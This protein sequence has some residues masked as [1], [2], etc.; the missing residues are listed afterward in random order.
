MIS[1]KSPE[2]GSKDKKNF[3]SKEDGIYVCDNYDLGLD[4]ISKQLTS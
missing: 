4:K 1:V 2:N 3:K